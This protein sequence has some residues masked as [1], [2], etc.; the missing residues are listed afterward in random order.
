MYDLSGEWDMRIQFL[1][2][3]ARH[4]LRFEQAGEALS[5]TSALNTVLNRYREMHGEMSCRYKRR[6]AMRVKV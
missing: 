2:G 3:E 6:F 5:G 4:S 1:S